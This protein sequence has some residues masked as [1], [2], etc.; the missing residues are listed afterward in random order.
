[1]YNRFSVERIIS[2]TYRKKIDPSKDFLTVGGM[3][4]VS[5][6]ASGVVFQNKK[7]IICIDGD[8]SLLMHLGSILMNSNLKISLIY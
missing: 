3:G 8:G 1:M 7:N 2:I 4:H 5:Q 6:I